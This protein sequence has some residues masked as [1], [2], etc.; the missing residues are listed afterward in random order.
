MVRASDRPPRGY[1]A[2][3]R[4][5]SPGRPCNNLVHDFYFVPSTSHMVRLGSIVR[6]GG[7]R[8]VAGASRN[9][10]ALFL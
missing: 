5:D 2:L 1:N 3:V 9:K 8:P 7:K 10:T 4:P 6:L